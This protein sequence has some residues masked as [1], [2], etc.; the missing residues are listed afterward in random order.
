MSE[1]RS[2]DAVPSGAVTAQR[3]AG[4]ALAPRNRRVTL[5]LIVLA[6][7]LAV[8][9]L[10]GL[11]VT[12]ETRSGAAYG[13]VGRLAAL[14]QQ[15]T[16]LA[17][18]MADERSSAAAFISGGRPAAGL[19]ALR[20]QYAITDGWAAGVRRLVARLGHGYPAQTRVGAAQVLASIAKLPGLRGQTTRSRASALAV[21]TPTVP[22]ATA[23]MNGICMRL[24]RK[25]G[26]ST[27]SETSF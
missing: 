19:S 16:G 6:A 3:A 17:R 27:A 24:D 14:D 2:A 21:I 11:R 20:R 4:P 8:L 7:V 25:T 13:Q 15:V 1:P 23:C 26:I 5:L 12:D 10:T 22:R 9:A 18:A